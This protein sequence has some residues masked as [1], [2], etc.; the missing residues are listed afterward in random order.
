MDFRTANRE[1]LRD[2]APVLLDA[3]GRLK[4][5]PA[6][7]LGETTLEE[8][9]WFGVRH[10]V[11]GLVTT[12]LVEHLRGFIGSRSAIE[13]GA[14]HGVLAQAL[15]IAATDNRQQEQPDI[16]AYYA[17]LRQPVVRYGDNV[18]KLDAMAAVRKYR[19]QVVIASW[20]THRYD[21]RRPRAG[22]NM[23]GVVEEAVISACE[24]YVFIGNERVHAAKSIWA[25][26]HTRSTPPWLYSRATNG[27][28]DFIAVW[29]GR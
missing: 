9:G 21:E 27:S 8:R 14:G 29:S 4:V 15:G 23:H 10:G 13:I 19:P 11:Y 17:L 22:G 3:S 2:L 16:K 26:P 6:S 18:E 25:L 12:E 5:V 1:G 7:V 20:V 24:H 28:G